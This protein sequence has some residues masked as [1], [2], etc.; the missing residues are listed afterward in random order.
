MAS[1]LPSWTV[2]RCRAFSASQKVLLD[3]LFRFCFLSSEYIQII[4]ELYIFI[5]Y[6]IY[7]KKLLDELIRISIRDS[8]NN[9]VEKFFSDLP[10]RTNSVSLDSIASWLVWI[11]QLIV[12]FF[13]FLLLYQPG[14]TGPNLWLNLNNPP[15][16]I[17]A[18]PFSF[19]QIFIFIK[20]NFIIMSAFW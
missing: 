16:Y 9:M 15:G 3:I 7:C 4:R 12:F 8:I 11:L 13:F 18:W 10:T 14:S 1:G 17:T 5:V 6:V 20:Y 2:Y 19:V